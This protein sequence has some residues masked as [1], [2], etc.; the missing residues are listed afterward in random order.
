MAEWRDMLLL[1]AGFVLSVVAGLIGAAIQRVL[2]RRGE[3]R[4]LN[5]LLNFGRDELLFVF[6]HREEIP[7]AI[8][9]RTSTEDFVAMNNVISALIKIG[10]KRKIGVRD[11]GRLSPADKKKNL[12]IICSPK[13]NSFS[14]EFQE[15]LQMTG[16]RFFRFER[17]EFSDEWQIT[18]GD[19]V[20]FSESYSQER[21]YLQDGCARHDLASKS[22]ND[23]AVITK[24]V[25]P[26]NDKNKVVVVAGIRGLGTWGAAE[27]LK[28][29][30]SQIYESLS[31]DEKDADFSALVK[32]RYDN[33]DITG[34][35]VRT[36]MTFER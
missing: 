6:P 21:Q 29:E 23:Y 18:E 15:K 33:C 17:S 9:P 14:Q 5:Q 30:W 11:T 20:Y 34:I 7:E 13:S 35:D 24:R 1:T 12:V 28:K 25:N 19:G 36:V 3:M 22:F 26:W 27:C 2:S 10:W 4:P 32:I 31:K 16:A 8:L